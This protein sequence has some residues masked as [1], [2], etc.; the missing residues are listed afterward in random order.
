M[1]LTKTLTSFFLMAVVA[2]T[3]E[4]AVFSRS[5]G[6]SRVL[7]L[8]DDGTVDT[9]I[10]GALLG[11]VEMIAGVLA[12][13]LQKFLLD[14][15]LPAN[16]L[17]PLRPLSMVLCT[18]AAFWAVLLICM[19]AAPAGRLRPVLDVL[20]MAAFN[21]CVLGVLYITTR[22]G[23][24]LAETLGFALGSAA[25]YVLA[26]LVVTEGQRKLQG[27]AVPQAFRGLP[28]NLIYIGILALAIYAFT[29]HM[30]LI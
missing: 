7:K 26:V 10:F 5:L 29:G 8:V 1:L 21:T 27:R 12:F 19:K 23:F 9:V 3:A 30:V 13:F 25:G 2:V 22:Q 6:V 20:P 16:W 4:N 24:T 15:Y 14:P 17:S 28:A 18:V 11:A